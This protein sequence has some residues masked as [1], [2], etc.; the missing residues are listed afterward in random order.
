MSR[1]SAGRSH[2]DAV[3]P[4]N[5]VLVRLTDSIIDLVR[6]S[7]RYSLSIPGRGNQSV[8][9]HRRSLTPSPPGAR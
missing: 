1:V 6:E 5:V 7:R 2:E 9:D 3:A 8:Y 4:R